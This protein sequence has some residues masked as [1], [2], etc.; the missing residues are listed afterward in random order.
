MPILPPPGRSSVRC[1]RRRGRRDRL[2]KMQ[3]RPQQQRRHSEANKGRPTRSST[4]RR[5]AHTRT[6]WRR[7]RHRR[8]Q[9]QPPRHSPRLRQLPKRLNLPLWK[10]QNSLSAPRNRRSWRRP[11]R[12]GQ[13][14]WSTTPAPRCSK[15]GWPWR[16]W[17]NETSN[18]RRRLSW[19]KSGTDSRIRTEHVTSLSQRSR[20]CKRSRARRQLQ[21]RPRRSLRRCSTLNNSVNKS[22]PL[23]RL[24]TRRNA[25]LPTRRWR[26][27]WAPW[28]TGVADSCPATHS[29]ARSKSRSC[30]C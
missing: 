24:P 23:A 6:R 27:R 10:E 4:S 11:Q 2:R 30:G 22:S 16:N 13:Q 9:R 18:A 7:R 21:R 5:R 15:C 8:Q 14:L 19:S 26:W 20:R 17:S 25:R 12:R 29:N 3:R 1:L 28:E